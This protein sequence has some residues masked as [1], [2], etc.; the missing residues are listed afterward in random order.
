M[1]FDLAIVPRSEALAVVEE[2]VTAK[3]VAKA[4]E[5]QCNAWAKVVRE[6]MPDMPLRYDPQ[7]NTIYAGPIH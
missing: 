7:T 1:G 4:Y 2:S 6:L 3:N 5:D